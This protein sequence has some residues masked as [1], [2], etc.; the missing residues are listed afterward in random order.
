MNVLT[1][2]SYL[3]FL[4]FVII[5][6]K[7]SNQIPNSDPQKVIICGEIMN[8][9]AMSHIRS[10]GL[11]VPDAALATQLN[12]TSDIDKL[13]NFRFEIERYLPQDMM[14]EY[15]CLHSIYAHP[16][17]SIYITIDAA[18][19]EEECRFS[20][21]TF[22]GDRSKANADINEVMNR[23][24]KHQDQNHGYLEEARDLS[25]NKYKACCDSLRSAYHDVLQKWISE[26]EPVDEI[27][28]WAFIMIESG[29]Y[30]E[31]LCLY[32]M[33]YSIFNRIPQ[34]KVILPDDCDRFINEI[35]EYKGNYLSNT[36]FTTSLP[37]FLRAFYGTVTSRVLTSRK[38]KFDRD[39][40]DAKTLKYIRNL[41]DPILVQL[42][43]A[44][45][46]ATYLEQGNLDAYA[47][48]YSEHN[49][50]LTARFLKEPLAKKYAELRRKVEQP[51][52]LAE[53]AKELNGTPATAIMDSIINKH[54]NKVVY[55][56][57]WST[58]CAP[59]RELMPHS[60]KLKE[61]L[62][63]DEVAFVYVCMG[64]SE[65]AWRTLISG[66]DYSGYHYYANKDQENY[67]R[68]AFGISVIPHY[69]L[70]DKKGKLVNKGNH[71]SPDHSK[72][73]EE[74]EKL[75]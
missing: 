54:K 11:I 7:N 34:S 70:Y 32:P 23:I 15:V 37:N 30:Y 21:L 58:S 46:L 51:D 2:L 20:T 73:K 48:Y 47:K 24:L 45:I 75:L 27:Q 19:F 67:L 71:L 26:T 6:C 5:S 61:K 38:V 33:A 55:L 14:L 13:G 39:I 31:Q 72:T 59:C 16:G 49:E 53:F 44:Q 41:D 52:Q 10:V 1:K 36:T 64:A 40:L 4:G 22:S 74:I 60:K 28:D 17:D 25:F 35:P 57:F 68:S 3:L 18:K 63:S 56:D 42:F 29:Y 43:V 69:V 66:S 9:D 62:N 65:K 12:Y 8:Q 50:L